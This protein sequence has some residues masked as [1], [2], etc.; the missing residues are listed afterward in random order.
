MLIYKLFFFM[1]AEL[2]DRRLNVYRVND[3]SCRGLFA[4][5]GLKPSQVGY[6]VTSRLLCNSVGWQGEELKARLSN[7]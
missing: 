4:L 3:C 6:N 1:I 5:N 2:C 7:V